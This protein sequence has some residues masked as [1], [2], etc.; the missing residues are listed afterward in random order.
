[1]SVSSSSPYTSGLVTSNPI[2]SWTYFCWWIMGKICFSPSAFP[3]T[4]LRAM[5]MCWRLVQRLG[6]PLA[7]LYVSDLYL[8]MLPF[9]WLFN[10]CS[11]T[12]VH[13]CRTWT[14]LWPSSHQC[15]Q[16]T[17]PWTNKSWHNLVRVYNLTLVT[18]HTSG[19]LI[20]G[21]WY[22][23]RLM[24]IHLPYPQWPNNWGCWF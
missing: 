21:V 10:K 3:P 18:R 7:S 9:V 14:P 20:S 17:L 12:L 5:I 11:R 16:S 8:A 4:L 6:K 22:S 2:T 24:I 15:L 13:R 1:M 19:S 23:I